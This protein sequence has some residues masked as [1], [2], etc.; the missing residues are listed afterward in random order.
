MN[1]ANPAVGLTGEYGAF[2][3][4]ELRP[5]PDALGTSIL[6]SLLPP[7]GTAGVH[8]PPQLQFTWKVPFS[9]V[10]AGWPA[11][12]AATGFTLR[13]DEWRNALTIAGTP[14][15]LGV[16]HSP[17]SSDSRNRIQTSTGGRPLTDFVPELRSEHAPVDWRHMGSVVIS[18]AAGRQVS[19]TLQ[20]VKNDVAGAEVEPAFRFSVPSGHHGR[21]RFSFYVP[22]SPPDDTAAGEFIVIAEDAKNGS[23]IHRVNGHLPPGPMRW[24]REEMYLSTYEVPGGIAQSSRGILKA[25]EIPAE[26]QPV[27]TWWKVLMSVDLRATPS[28]NEPSVLQ[29]PVVP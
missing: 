19:L 11:Q 13:F 25:Q 9:T 7:P 20:T 12:A 23:L 17:P 5:S 14:L 28:A 24:Q 18:E 27:K 16:F 1:N 22:A 2:V 10:S 29:L 8:P 4:T 3:Q 26:G 15:R 6:I 21:I